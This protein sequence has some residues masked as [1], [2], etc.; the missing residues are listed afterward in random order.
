MLRSASSQA[1]CSC[2]SS[3]RR[4]CAL[5][6]AALGILAGA[7]FLQQLLPARHVL[8]KERQF[9]LAGLAAEGVLNTPLP[10]IAVLLELYRLLQLDSQ[11]VPPVS[12]R[13]HYYKYNFIGIS[14]TPVQNRPVAKPLPYSLLLKQIF[15][16]FHELK[17]Y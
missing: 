5:E 13:A 10:P 7:L 1:R 3:C 15:V 9:R 11:L 16:F 17:N 12:A 2:S 4:A 14:S 8:A 6:N